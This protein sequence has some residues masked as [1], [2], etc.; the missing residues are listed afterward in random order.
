MYTDAARSAV[1]D[2]MRTAAGCERYRRPARLRHRDG[3][4]GKPFHKRGKSIETRRQ[5]DDVTLL[6]EHAGHGFGQLRLRDQ[7]REPLDRPA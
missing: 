6:V 7:F 2:G 1:A 3:A 5:L 4:V